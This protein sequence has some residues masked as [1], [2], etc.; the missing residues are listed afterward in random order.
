MRLFALFALLALP[1]AASDFTGVYARID[2]VEMESDRVQIWGVFSVAKTTD[3]NDYEKPVRGYLYF[4][5]DR[6]GQAARNEWSDLKSLAGTGEVVAFSVRGAPIRV[7]N[8]GDPSSNPDPYRT[9]MGIVK[10]RG[11]TDY[12]P[13]R[14]VRDFKD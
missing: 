7:R 3:R 4:T 1:A 13:V 2:R 6:D 9:N 11:R 5:L 14:A 12:E 8:S 10:V